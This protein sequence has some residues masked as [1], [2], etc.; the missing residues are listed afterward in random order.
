MNAL[1]THST[2]CCN[3]SVRASVISLMKPNQEF[4]TSFT[5]F[6]PNCSPHTKPPLSSNYP[7]VNH[8]FATRF[9]I[10]ISSHIFTPSMNTMMT[11]FVPSPL[12]VHAARGDSLR[13]FSSLFLPS[14]SN[15]SLSSSVGMELGKKPFKICCPFV[16]E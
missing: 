14:G 6:E 1:L 10:Y 2:V 4:I 15:F 12:L 5:P 3:G 9:S 16:L 8:R 11:T 13:Q 7:H